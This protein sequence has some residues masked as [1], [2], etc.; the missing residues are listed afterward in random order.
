MEFLLDVWFTVTHGKSGRR[1]Q[2]VTFSARVFGTICQPVGVQVVAS[3]A[4][5]RH[6]PLR[7]LE[8]SSAQSPFECPQRVDAIVATLAALPAH[9]TVAPSD[10]GTTPIEAVHHLSL[11]HI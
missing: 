8:N 1:R 3:E 6:S 5:R 10:W 4:H 7:E 9:T 2:P 11:I